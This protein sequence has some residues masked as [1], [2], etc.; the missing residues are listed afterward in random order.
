[1]W[2]LVTTVSVDGGRG[3]CGTYRGTVAYTG[4][5]EVRFRVETP[6]VL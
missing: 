5:V 6:F 1:M 3:T 2:I 4:T